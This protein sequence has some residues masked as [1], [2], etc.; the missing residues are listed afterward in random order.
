MIAAAIVGAAV[1]GAAVQYYNS[2]K[3]RG[4]SKE[5]LKQ[6][7]E[8]FNAI[9]PPDYDL[10]IQDPPKLHEQALQSPKFSDPMEAPK[11]NLDALKPEQFKLIGKMD[12]QIAAYVAEAN[13]KLIE[14]TKDMDTAR[15]AQMSALRR[16]Q[17]IG[18]GEFDPQYAEAVQKAARSAQGEAQSRQ[19][20]IMQDFARRGFAGSGL[21][22]ASQMGAASQSMDR[23]AA[24]NQAAASEAYRNRLN[25]LMQGAQLGGQ[26]N[27]EDVGLQSRNADIINGFNERMSRNRQAY[28]NQRVAAL[29]NAQ[30]YNL[31]TAQG[32]ANMNVNAANENAQGHQRRLDELTKYGAGFAQDERNRAD[33]NAQQT[34]ANQDAERRY[35]N[36][37]ITSKAAWEAGERE[38]LNKIRSQQF[39]D[40]MDIARGKSGIASQRMEAD[41]SA[42][43]DRN[44]MVQ[45]VT[46]AGMMGAMAYGNSQ[47]AQQN[48]YNRA[49]MA[50]Y[51]RKGEWM[52]P[53]ESEKY[54]QSYEGY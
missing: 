8:A 16:F 27:Q 22:L 52:G 29:N 23:T 21:N 25:A 37:I 11:F 31:G 15:Q 3:A 42:A 48:D 5:H 40:Q 9:K 54:R 46:N 28:E 20:S 44:A 1:I 41:M 32:L 6:I 39:Q 7:E 45:G 35:L 30:Q 18:K 43:R 14:R 53:E 33:R 36:S 19:A 10:T 12:P 26:I 47:A 38:K 51:E 34:Y 49:N 24:A 2:E 50:Y 13:P 4:A 17:D